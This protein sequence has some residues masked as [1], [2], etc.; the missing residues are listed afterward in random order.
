MYGE[1]TTTI[2]TL[3]GYPLMIIRIPLIL[4]CLLIYFVGDVINNMVNI[5]KNLYS[6]K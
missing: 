6:L 5:L 4:I 3:L 2:S 1:S